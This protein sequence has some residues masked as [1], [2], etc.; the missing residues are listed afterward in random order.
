MIPIE[1]IHPILVHFPIVFFISLAV[2]DIVALA[3]GHGVSARTALGNLSTALAVLAAA[4]A[5][6]AFIFGDEALEI[7]EAAGFNNPVGEIHENLGTLTTTLFSMWAIV[8]VYWWLRN[9]AVQ[10]VMKWLI[11]VAEA[12]GALLI[13]FTAYYG[14]LL[15]YTYGVNI[16]R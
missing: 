4:S 3:R 10:G 16:A 14:G 1:H 6:A 9:I 11:A 8:R 2:L 13:V 12:G 5:I 7:A 15:V